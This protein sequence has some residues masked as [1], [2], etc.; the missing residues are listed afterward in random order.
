MF[1]LDKS[2]RFRLSEPIIYDGVETFGIFVKPS[3]LIQKP[4][5]EFIGTFKISNIIEGRP[6]LVANQIYG[7]PLLDWVL[8]SFNAAYYD[9][10]ARDVLN[11]PRANALIMYPVD[12]IVFPSLS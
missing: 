2:S 3:W 11:W 8:I 9:N 10:G 4:S 1:Q 6:D 5:D 7:T 12:S